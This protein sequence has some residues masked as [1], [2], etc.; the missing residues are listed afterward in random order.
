MNKKIYLIFFLVISLFGLE[1]CKKSKTDPTNQEEVRPEDEIPPTTGNRTQLSL[2]SIFLYAK[3]VYYWNDKLPTYKAFNPRQYTG[4]TDLDKYEAALFGI[5][6]YSLNKY[7][8]Y[9][10]SPKYSYISDQTEDNPGATGFV[11]NNQTL[12]VDLSGNGY[13]V[14]IRLVSYLLDDV[15]AKYIPFV[16]AV[17]QN[18]PAEKAGV[19]RGW[20]ISKANGQSYGTNYTTEISSLNAALNK[21]SVT[22]ELVNYIT[23]ATITVT[24]NKASYK[25]SPV[26][27][28]KIFTAGSKKIGYF[29]MARFSRLTV[30]SSADP[31]DTDLDPVFTAFANA[32]VT[33]LIVDLRYNGGGYIQTAEYL[34]NLI[35]TSANN[36]KVMYTE[37]YNIGMQSNK[38]TI[39]KNQ[40]LLDANGDIQRFN[41]N[42]VTYYDYMKNPY[43]VAN[44]T[45]TF[46]KKGSLNSIQNVI[47]LV[48]DNT[49]SSSELVINSLKPYMNVKLVGET[50][51]GK[52]IGFYPIV[53]ENRYEVYFSMFESK[54]ASGT[55][56]Y[57]TGMV[58]DYNQAEIIGYD[59]D[60]KPIYRY[61]NL[62]D[63]IRY[64][65]GDIN[66]AYLAQALS[67]LAPGATITTSS[68]GKSILAGST[69]LAIPSNTLNNSKVF[70]KYKV[71]KEEFI[72]MLEEPGR[73]KQ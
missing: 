41:G 45:A 18:S 49:A 13:D 50:T 26:Y 68:S 70:G 53:I 38:A 39:L 10:T 47:F 17:Y 30:P 20:Y 64:D 63:D 42:I 61:P 32:G 52:P 23:K 15:K 1:A 24:L 44:N 33:D 73:K 43:S 9:Q 48:T 66:E 72:G 58:P 4:A 14:G 60:K 67:V 27:A 55:G 34:I 69:T 37:H 59:K 65:F 40:P 16:T 22:L 54:N 6:N 11:I 36:G 7:D 51:Y 46:S 25:S 21:S 57:Y 19:K 8:V 5:A 2:D 3:Q 56:G 29:A 35:S 28:N 62:W 71:G 12:S 31:S